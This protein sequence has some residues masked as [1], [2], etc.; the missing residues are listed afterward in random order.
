MEQDNNNQRAKVVEKITANTRVK[1]QTGKKDKM[2]QR[3]NSGKG[4]NINTN[5]K[6]TPKACKWVFARVLIIATC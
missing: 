1:T 2:F 6:K 5:I 4:D 3:T